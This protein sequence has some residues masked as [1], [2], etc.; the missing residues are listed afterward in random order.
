MKRRG[1][2]LIELLV[3][4][5]ILGLLAGFLLPVL[6]QGKR[7][8]HATACLSNLHQIGLALELYIQDNASRLPACAPMPSLNTNLTPITTALAPY[9]GA[10]A[11]WRCPADRT[12][13]A[14]EQTSYEWNQFLNGVS[15]DRPEDWSPATRCLVETIFG[16]RLNTP[17]VGDAA[18]FHTAKGHY[19][20]KNALY[21][22]GRVLKGRL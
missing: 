1:F 20:G 17:L 3:V 14:M 4:I 21:F 12:Y 9:L 5:G 22:D 15:Y 16:G 13:F 18:A 19:T 2:T 6:G 10:P 8:A 11:V 7:A